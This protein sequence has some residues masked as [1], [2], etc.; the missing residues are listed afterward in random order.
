MF[1]GQYISTDYHEVLLTDTVEFVLQK[2]NEN[3]SKFLAAVEGKIFHG[4]VSEELL[5]DQI[6]TEVPINTIK[7][8]FRS[9]YLFDYQHIYD[10]LQLITTYD[11]CFIPVLNRKHEYL[12]VLTKQDLLIALNETLGNDEG[13]IIVLELGIRDN[14]LSHIAR[15]I[16]TENTSILSTAIHRL[17]D[18]SKLEMTIKVNKTNISAV[19]SSLWRNDY[20]VKATFRDGGEQ[21]DIQ[22]RYDLLMNYLDL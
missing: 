16:E 10:A 17:P 1:I 21:S 15:I 2:M 11:Y 18:S 20:V 19:V 4:L 13:A 14:A 6:D 22:D 9:V 5:L 12:G 8:H 3:H 7:L